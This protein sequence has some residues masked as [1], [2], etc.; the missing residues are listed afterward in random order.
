MWQKSIQSAGFRSI[1]ALQN[2]KKPL[3]ANIEEGDEVLIV[4]DTE[5]DPEVWKLIAMAVRDLGGHPVIS[6]IEPPEMDYYNPPPSVAEQMTDVDVVVTCTTTAMLHSP[7]GD[8]AM[9][10]DVPIVCMDGGLTIDM[11]TKGAATA[12]YQQI[13]RIEYEIGKKVFEGGQ[14][15]HLTSEH[16]T[17]LTLS[18]ED[19]VFL[20]REPDS[21]TPALEAYEK[22]PG[23]NAVVFPRGE[24]NVPP[25]PDLADGTIVFDTTMHHLGRLEEPIELD[26]DSGTIVDIRGGFQARELE[27]VL[28]EYGDEDAYRMPT[29]FSVGANPKARITGC[30]REDKNILGC[31]HIGLGTNADVGGDIRS[32]LHMDGVIA[33]PTLKIDGELMIDKGE[34]LP[35]DI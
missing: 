10:A 12:D 31:I 30:Q 27:R 14:E 5:H 26:I 25:N 3:V 28:E 22:R 34:I 13:E 21:D 7:A 24:F 23:F 33:Q 16:G 19:R 29:E 1:T 15:A 2:V 6:L 11:L 9:A 17:D 8:S 32:K 18:I 20:Y 4:T 35:I